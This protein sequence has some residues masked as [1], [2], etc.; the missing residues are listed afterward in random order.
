MKKKSNTVLYIAI[1]I[2]LVLMIVFFILLIIKIFEN[3]APDNNPSDFVTSSQT[4]TSESIPKENAVVIPNK[5]NSSVSSNK[6]SS[7]QKPVE[8]SYNET[9]DENTDAD[10]QSQED[11]SDWFKQSYSL[12][13]SS[14]KAELRAKKIPLESQKTELTQQRDEYSKKKIYAQRLLMEEYANMGLLESGQ[15]QSALNN[16]N[17][18]YNSKIS[19]LDNQISALNA[20]IN[21][22][23]SEIKNPNPN[24]IL[25]II[26]VNNNLTSSQVIEYYK[27]YMD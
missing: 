22:I 3:K 20:S 27:K 17:N 23:D 2:L 5:S 26:A 9:P 25:A 12:A 1:S 4:T 16:L 14:Y 11:K 15:Y 24:Q 18:S 8:P 10:V 13:E 21:Q 6:T 7:I 19:E